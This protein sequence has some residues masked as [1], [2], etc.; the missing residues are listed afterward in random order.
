M[1]ESCYSFSVQQ[2]YWSRELASKISMLFGLSEVH[3]LC[4]GSKLLG[5]SLL[6]L[7]RMNSGCSKVALGSVFKLLL[8]DHEFPWS[9]THTSLKK[10]K[11]IWW[12]QDISSALKIL[13]AIISRIWYNKWLVAVLH[14]FFCSFITWRKPER[15]NLWKFYLKEFFFSE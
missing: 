5:N 13:T 11:D 6:S 3:L 15:L 10:K 12:L 7:M 8:W 9:E 4:Y 1:N 14:Y 2:R